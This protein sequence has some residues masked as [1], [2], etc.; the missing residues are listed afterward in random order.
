MRFLAHRQVASSIDWERLG[1]KDRVI[2]LLCLCV[3]V[4]TV[5][6]PQMRLEKHLIVDDASQIKF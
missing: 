1:G 4:T 6:P 3:I 5:L 2:I